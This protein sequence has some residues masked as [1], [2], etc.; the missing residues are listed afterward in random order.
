[1]TLRQILNVL[2]K[3]AWMVALVAAVA[4]A[5][6]AGYLAVRDV[7]YT[8][9]GSL[10]LNT[11]VTDATSTGEIGGVVVDLE[12]ETVTSPDVLD[13]AAT[14]LGEPSGDVLAGAVSASLDD[15]A[16]TGRL[17]IT[18]QGLSPEISQERAAAVMTAYSA[19]VVTQVDTALST[20]TQRHQAAIEQAQELQRQV[21]ANP[22]NLIASTN[23]TLALSRMSMT[24]SAIDELTAAADPT[25]VVRE[26]APGVTTDPSVLT[27]LLLAIATGLVLGMGVV[28][29]RDQF[30][31]RLRS[32]DEVERLTQVPG[33]GELGWDRSVRRLDPPLPVAGRQRTDLSEGLRSLRASIQVLVPREQSVVVITSVEP[34]D[35]KSF[36]S[37][38]LA[39]AWARAGKKVIVVGGDLR[40]PDLGR[41]FTDAADGEGLAELL[42]DR[43]EAGD[44]TAMDVAARLNATDYPGLQVLPSGAEPIDPADLLA[45][46]RLARVV[47]HLR[48]LADV[49]VIDSPPAMGLAD[50]AL[51]TAQSDGAVVIASVRRTD[52]TLLTE[53]VDGLEATGGE[54]LGVV[55]NRGTRKLPKTYAVYYLQRGASRGRNAPDDVP[56]EPN[57]DTDRAPDE[58]DDVD[59][60][61]DVDVDT[62]TDRDPDG[63]VLVP[64]PEPDRIR[65]VTVA[66]ASGRRALGV[67]RQETA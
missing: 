23:L 52:R 34:G 10:R 48:E 49:V 11:L 30:D 40:R 42:D 20:L 37:A 62:D 46:P 55:V 66:K 60:D 12:V 56:D 47:G 22:E 9:E 39:L 51:L 18:A 41:Y 8:S 61:T 5:A 64:E 32:I 15:T 6:A 43:G 4:A 1:M 59:T 19:Y 25:S 3:R 44:L 28:L 50:A 45:G 54:V 35:G 58:P 57:A 2:W 13:A 63:D 29:I 14:A 38:N 31:N 24:Q 36:V 26:P 7:T 17:Y 16:S 27:T 53:A 33:L 21:T 65:E 67:R